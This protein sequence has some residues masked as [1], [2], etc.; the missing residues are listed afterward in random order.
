MI[1]FFCDWGRQQT[2]FSILGKTSGAF[3]VNSF[4]WWCIQIQYI[5]IVVHLASIYKDS[6]AFSFNIY[7]QWCI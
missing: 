7:G 5:W 4:G 6:G 3:S 1:Q 2:V